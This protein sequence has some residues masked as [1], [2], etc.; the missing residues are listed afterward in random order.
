MSGEGTPEAN[1]RRR[2]K[3]KERRLAGDTANRIN[4]VERLFDRVD[5]LLNKA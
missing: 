2:Q 5:V 4:R 1:L 3:R